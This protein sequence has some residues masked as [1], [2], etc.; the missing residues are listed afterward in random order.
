MGA[1]AP[2]SGWTEKPLIDGNAKSSAAPMSESF[3]VEDPPSIR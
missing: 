2:K 3:G 1:E